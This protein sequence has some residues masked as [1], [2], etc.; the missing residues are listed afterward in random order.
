MSGI[1]PR[2]TRRG[3]RLDWVKFDFELARD[4]SIEPTAKALYAAIASFVDVETRRSSNEIGTIA[5][6]VS[7]DVPTRKRLAECIGKSVDTVDRCIT[8]L[9]QRGLLKVHRRTH[10]DNPKVYVPSEYELLPYQPQPVVAP[11]AVVAPPRKRMPISATKRARVLARD[12][13]RCRKCSAIED[14]TIDHI[15]HWSRGGSNADDNLRVLCRSCN[16]RRSDGS[17][18]GVDA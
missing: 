1:Q 12:G 7:E 16:S 9:E 18:D 13:H 5:N 10:P 6:D 17:L 11:A 8:S 15:K 14:L 3:T 2:A 4:G